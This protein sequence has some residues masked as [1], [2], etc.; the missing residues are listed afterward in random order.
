M[1]ARAPLA[2]TA[3]AERDTAPLSTVDVEHLDRFAAIVRQSKH[4]ADR[5]IVEL[6]EMAEV[7]PSP[8]MIAEAMDRH[9][10]AASDYAAD[11][12]GFF[13]V[14]ERTRSRR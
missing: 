11:A 10:R 13:A 2:K 1:N 6:T 4:L 14:W 7:H 9:Q 12:K 8:A 5:A 3:I